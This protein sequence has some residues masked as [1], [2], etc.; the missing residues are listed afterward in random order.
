MASHSVVMARAA[1]DLNQSPAGQLALLRH[2]AHEA[3]TG[4]IPGPL[5]AV[6]GNHIVRLQEEIQRGLDKLERIPV[7]ARPSEHPVLVKV[8]DG[9]AYQAE[10]GAFMGE[11]PLEIPNSAPPEVAEA[12]QTNLRRYLT[13]GENDDGGWAA[14]MSMYD[15]LMYLHRED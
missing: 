9:A 6:L 3:V 10:R 12:I 8:F 11:P 4:D 13:A 2:D 1:R 14:F 7:H 5:I 15:M